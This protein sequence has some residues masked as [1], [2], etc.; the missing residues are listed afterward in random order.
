MR[1]PRPSASIPIELR[2]RNFLHDG[3]TTATEQV[4][5]E[6]V[7]LDQLLDRALDE[8]DYHARRAQFAREN[9]TSPVKRGMGIAAFYHGSGFTG[10]GERY[11]NSLAGVDV[12]PEGKVRVLVSST[13]F[14]QGTNTVLTQ[15]AAEAIGIDY[16]DVIDGAAGHRHCSQQRA[17]RCFAHGHGGGPAD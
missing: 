8:S 6:P 11:L 10:S 3:D 4:M 12:T 17:H 16:G 7:I 15:I 5:R 13:E 9:A 14:G 1:S 2:R